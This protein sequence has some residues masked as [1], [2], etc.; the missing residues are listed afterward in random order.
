L[1]ENWKKP[2]G[3]TLQSYTIITTEPNELTREVHD[4]MPVILSPD[5]YERWLDPELKDVD[6]LRS[7]LVPYPAT[8][9]KAYPVS[10]LVN[11]P[12]NDSPKCIEPA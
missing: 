11:S 3:E 4:R 2:D 10:T 7:M 12:K 6:G 5:D 9:M 8:E 1:W